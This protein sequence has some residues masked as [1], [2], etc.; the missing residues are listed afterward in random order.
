MGLTACAPA[1]A[2]ID[3][4][5]QRRFFAERYRCSVNEVVEESA[6]DGDGLTIHAGCGYRAV[7]R[8]YDGYRPLLDRYHPAR[9][10]V[11]DAMQR[12]NEESFV[13]RM[14]ERETGCKPEEVRAA[15]HLAG[16]VDGHHP[17]QVLGCGRRAIYHCLN[18][19]AQAFPIPVCRPGLRRDRAEN[20]AKRAAQALVHD[21]GEAKVVDGWALP[22]RRLG[23]ALE[24]C[25][26]SWAFSCTLPAEPARDPS[27]AQLGRGDQVGPTVRRAFAKSVDCTSSSIDVTILGR[28]YHRQQ[29]FDFVHVNGCSQ[30][31]GYRCRTKLPAGTQTPKRK[32]IRCEAGSSWL[33]PA[34]VKPAIGR[35][36]AELFADCSLGERSALRCPDG[37]RLRAWIRKDNPSHGSVAA[38]CGRR[39]G[40]L[41]CVSVPGFRVSGPRAFCARDDEQTALHER[42]L[43]QLARRWRRHVACDQSGAHLHGDEQG[44]LVYEVFGCGHRDAYACPEGDPDPCSCRAI[45][46]TTRSVCR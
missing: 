20:A 10:E 43:E 46:G 2:T 4:E 21:C 8:C 23:V 13:G 16:S 42:R 6:E 41:T 24:G 1:V 18:R 9:C 31:L 19:D 45:D 17:L 5:R 14:F 38:A 39:W 29:L 3:P 32:T 34:Q 28:T 11:V 30:R 37:C 26:S 36:A 25:G 44:D 12:S 15:G 33:K 22:D 27:C 7:I 35:G 40:F